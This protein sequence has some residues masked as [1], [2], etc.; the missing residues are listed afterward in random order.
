MSMFRTVLMT[1]AVFS[2]L[3]STTPSLAEQPPVAAPPVVPP[4]VVEA[5]EFSITGLRFGADEGVVQVVREDTGQTDHLRVE[6]WTDNEIV[7]YIG[8][9]SNGNPALGEVKPFHLVIQTARGADITTP[10]FMV[11]GINTCDDPGMMLPVA[12]P[13]MH[14]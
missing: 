10:S 2:L 12:C 8:T 14:H 9:M 13:P 11:K 4:L 1:A 3:T 6:L 5:V 7:G